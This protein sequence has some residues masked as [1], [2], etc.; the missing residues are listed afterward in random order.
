M[1]TA[2][3]ASFAFY[4][5]HN[6]F[7]D[8][9]LTNYVNVRAEWRAW[10]DASDR[11]FATLQALWARLD[12]SAAWNES[13]T[14]TLWIQ[15][16]LAALGQRFAVQLSLQTPRGNKVPD[17]V[18]FSDEAGQAAAQGHGSPATEALLAQ[19]QGRAVAD[20]K[21]WD[22]P[23]DVALSD[24]ADPAISKNPVVQIDFYLRYSGL[25]WAVLTNG[26]L[27]RLYHR[28]SSKQFD[29]YYEVDL[30]ALLE[31]GDAQAFRY[32]YLFFCQPAFAP[33]GWLDSVLAGSREL[34]QGIS[35]NLKS[36]VYDALSALAQ[37]FFA[38][39][40]NDLEA[41]AATL[42]AIYDN[43]LIL[44]YRLL[45]VLF[46]ESRGLLPAQPSSAY[47]SYS[48]ARLKRTVAH[49]KD[50][51]RPAAAS[52]TILW[53]ALQELWNIINK[54]DAALGVP[55]YNG[56]L[57]SPTKHPFLQQ[58]RVGDRDLRRAI[59]LLA[60]ATDPQSSQRGFVDYR[61]LAVRH[62]GAIYEG[63]LEFTITVEDGEVALLN[64]KQERKASGSYYTP[65]YIVQYIVEQ[66]LGPLVDELE[67]THADN[68]TKLAEAILA[69]N[70]V[71]PAAGSGH[72]LVG[73]TDYLAQR[74]V[75][76]DLQ[77]TAGDALSGETALA[78]WRRRVVASCIYGVDLNPLAVELA[79][80]SLWL[81][82]VAKDRPLSFLD[83]HI[84][85]GN[86][87][88]GARL[89]ALHEAQPKRR[90]S[91]R[92]KEEETQA[93]AGQLSLFQDSAFVGH[94]RTAT[95]FMEDIEGTVQSS[96]ADIHKVEEAFISG[97]RATTERYRRLADLWT[98]QHF[99]VEIGPTEWKGL[100]DILLKGGFQVPRY[101]ELLHEVERI[102]RERHF[103]HWE[104]E[105]P[106]VFFGLSGQPLDD[107]AGFDAVIGNPPWVDVQ[108]MGE[109][110]K[111][112]QRQ[113]YSSATGKYDQYAVF[114]ELS[115][116]LISL[117]GKLGYIVQSKF[118]VTG[119]GKGLRSFL[120]ANANLLQ[121]VDL[122]DAPIF[123]DATT[124]PL[125]LLLSRANHIPTSTDTEVFSFPSYRNLGV[126]TYETLFSKLSTEKLPSSI[127]HFF[128]DE[129]AY[130]TEQPWR[131]E[132]KAAQS[133]WK[134]IWEISDPFHTHTLAINRS[135]TTGLNDAYIGKRELFDPFL[136]ESQFVRRML[137]AG[138]L[139]RYSITPSNE[140]IVFPYQRNEQGEPSL[141]N[142]DSAPR[143][144]AYFEERQDIL[145]D[146]RWYGQTV[147]E[148]GMSWYGYLYLSKHLLKPKL[149]FPKIT[150]KNTFVLDSLGNQIL[151]EPAYVVALDTEYS[152]H[153]LVA[154]LNS[155][156]LTFRMRQ[157]TTTLSGG[158]YE[159]QVQYVRRLPIR[160][161]DFT[162]PDDER[163]RLLAEGTALYDA[164][165]RGGGDAGALLRRFVEQRMAASSAQ[166]DVVHD[167]LAH[168][169]EQMIALNQE[170]QQRTEAF[171]LDLEGVSDEASF[172]VL[173]NKGKW[174][175][176]LAKKAALAPYVDA[177]SRSSRSIA[178]ALEW[179][180]GAFKA[181][182]GLLVKKIGNFSGIVAVYRDHAPT[183][184]AV[185]Q[186]I[187]HTDDLIDQI[188]YRLYG[189]T[190]EEIAIV[191]TK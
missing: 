137:R 100:R 46:A 43:S 36:Q 62:L 9:Y 60:R 104:L 148:A 91:K 44:L 75:Q 13:Q 151:L 166:T 93:E 128:M 31:H 4:S 39:P 56:G 71:D 152:S 3:Q 129:S 57:F 28:D 83:H 122:N 187:Q 155:K 23:L 101:G 161:I 150:N 181:F 6:L 174:E 52:R 14:E 176:S 66:T 167:L 140:Y 21:R 111:L 32:F 68:P 114:I 153:F 72:F 186:R 97:V 184:R 78:Y 107:Q 67:T 144:R 183:V 123:G 84:R 42:K 125:I 170:K 77:P 8:Y 175:Q 109:V 82:T 2:T 105:F 64:D 24:G 163:A 27:W 33:N 160:R 119:Y 106:E 113:I 169:A 172:D 188:V 76:R 121:L 141:V 88:V 35:D 81:N 147:V 87:L 149:L 40:D 5:N 10:A 165:Q 26:R 20:A 118:L 171:W 185:A 135:I 134:R 90:K 74:M 63:L 96:V 94:M 120:A 1:T 136:I 146:R 190:D 178:D 86:S 115:L 133:V 108:E 89:E 158:F 95:R 53:N 130:R 132:P 143:L 15:P 61:D 79:K 17:Y 47:Y 180:E 154:C 179:D 168:L 65:D 45:F 48:L 164:M 22:R 19:W 159:L 145:Q 59:D 177:E 12:P 112:F 116:T 126:P 98:A 131:L 92:K 41:D 69:L 142:L 85:V 29:S 156:L 124:Y 58:Y 18:F 7:S 34:A 16:V 173:R 189:L 25:T 99:G 11:C 138:D 30:A 117:R 127:A 80:L 70:V 49:D 50:S 182:V 38:L 102:A 103:F 139:H 37:G 73:A 157:E 54:G 110:D 51:Q 191:E 162:T 55:A